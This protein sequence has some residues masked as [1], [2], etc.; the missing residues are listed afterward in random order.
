M[1]IELVEK[2][3]NC[4]VDYFVC[5]KGLVEVICKVYDDFMMYMMK[6]E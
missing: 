5:L 3:E 6:E 4:Y 1:L 2:V